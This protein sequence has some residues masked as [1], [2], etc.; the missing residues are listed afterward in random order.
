MNGNT[1]VDVYSNAAGEYMLAYFWLDGDRTFDTSKN[2]WKF[3]GPQGHADVE[4]VFLAEHYTE[5]SYNNDD[6]SGGIVECRSASPRRASR[7]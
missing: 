2:N 4:G 1:T 7:N 3:W 5:L 6:G